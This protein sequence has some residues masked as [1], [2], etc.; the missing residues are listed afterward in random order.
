MCAAYFPSESRRTYNNRSEAEREGNAE[1][2]NEARPHKLDHIYYAIEM[3]DPHPERSCF[4]WCN[5]SRPGQALMWRW[6]LLRLLLPALSCWAETAVFDA[7]GTMLV[8]VPVSL[9]PLLLLLITV[10][11]VMALLCSSGAGALV[12]VLVLVLD[13]CWRRRGRSWWCY[14]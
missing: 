11:V 9:L 14:R 6:L 13:S 7:A 4:S 3:F 2:L 5:N 1:T 12:L 10:V 8:S